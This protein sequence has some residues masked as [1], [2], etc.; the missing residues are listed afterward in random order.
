MSLLDPTGRAIDRTS[1]RPATETAPENVT[2]GSGSS[3]ACPAGRDARVA[4]GTNWSLRLFVAAVILAA[5]ARQVGAPY[6]VFLALG[7][8]NAG[9]AARRARDR[10]R[11]HRRPARR[12][13]RH[14]GAPPVR[15]PHRILTVLEGES[16][17]NDAKPN[18]TP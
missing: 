8:A 1:A 6:P 2:A 4:P 17:L 11:R 16:L 18:E 10:A 9:I 7:G 14:R 13:R 5:A 3:G 12:G 15:P